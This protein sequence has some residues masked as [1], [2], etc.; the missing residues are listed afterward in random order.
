LADASRIMQDLDQ[1][2]RQGDLDKLSKY[3]DKL[4]TKA[5]NHAVH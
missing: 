3:H 2:V 5:N 4:K 1:G